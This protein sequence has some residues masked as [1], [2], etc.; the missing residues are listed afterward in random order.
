[1]IIREIRE[2]DRSAYLEMSETFYKSPAVLADIPASY[3]VNAFSEYLRGV[4]AKCFIFEED[5]G[6]V[7]YGIICFVYS[8]E[9]GGMSVL[10]DELYV[11]ENYRSRGFG[12]K[13]F[14]Y[15][16]TNYPAPRY[17]LDVEPDNVR[18]AA[19]YSKLGFSALGYSRMIKSGN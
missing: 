15:V 4:H 5:K 11:K 12:R 19:L 8:Q 17:M 1:M 13:F 2:G 14:E 10:F 6:A 3:R 18:A 7:G 9:A 16:F